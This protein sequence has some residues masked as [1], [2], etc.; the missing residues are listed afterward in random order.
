[1]FDT[2]FYHDER[3]KPA[4]D[5]VKE[6]RINSGM[7]NMKILHDNEEPHVAKIVKKYLDDE[8]ITIIDHLPYSPDLAP[9]DFRLFSKLKQSL[10][11]HSN[12]ESLKSQITEVLESIPQ[13]KYL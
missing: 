1:M 4:I 2:L 10:D 5:A 6:E 13:E 3:L 12:V 9:C 11:T 8:G 7:K